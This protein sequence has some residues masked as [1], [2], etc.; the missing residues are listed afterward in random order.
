MSHHLVLEDHRT[1]SLSI[2]HTMDLQSYLSL[3]EKIYGNR[4]G[5]EGQRA[6]LKTKTAIRIRKRMVDDICQG[7]VIPPI[8]LGVVLDNDTKSPSMKD[9][10]DSKSAAQVTDLLEKAP[11]D[12]LSII[13]GMQRTTALKEA[14]SLE[15][16]VATSTVR[17]ELWISLSIDKLIYR[18]LVLN[19]GQVPWDMKRQLE[20]IYQPILAKIRASV[21]GVDVLG[22]DKPARRTTSG[23]FQGAKLIE[24]FIAYSSKKVNTDIK[25]RVA[26]DFARLDATEATSSEHFIEY[27]LQAMR[28]LVELDNALAGA[29]LE[30]GLSGRMKSGRDIFT[31]GPAGVGFMAAS[32]VFVFGI[33]G[34]TLSESKI[35]ENAELYQKNV[36]AFI[37]KIP[38]QQKNELIEFADLATLNQQLDRKSGKVGEFER[39][40]FFKAFSVIFEN[41]D[42]LPSL[43]PCWVAY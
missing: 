35:E 27:F 18:M 16:K 3:V 14:L 30:E 11:E 19:T 10:K 12:S 20:T 7:A 2:I 6:P 9:F 26:E 39:E 21:V 23:Q 8:V 15:P 32:A 13:D 38:S 5:I 41:G 29:T 17:I 43:Q 22:L 31:S 37:S 34:V 36:D 28:K 1:N 4:G 33:P 24:F 40:Y 42:S 25:E